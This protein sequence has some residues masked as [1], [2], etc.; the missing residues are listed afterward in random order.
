M[1]LYRIQLFSV[2]R[3][4]DHQH[5]PV[6]LQPTVQTL[7]AYLL[8]NRHR[9][10]SREVLSGL[11]WGEM[12]ESKARR[13]LSTALWRLRKVLEPEDASRGDLVVTTNS[14]E[15]GL[16]CQREKVWLDVAAFEEKARCGLGCPSSEL[17]AA[18]IGQL[19]E[20]VDLYVGDLLEGFYA[21]WV[22]VHREWLRGQYIRCLGRLMRFHG[23]EGAYEKGIYYGRKILAIDPLR[24][25]IHRAMMRL[26]HQNGKWPQVLQQYESCRQ[27]LAEEL[28]I[29]PM[30]ETQALFRQLTASRSTR[31]VAHPQHDRFDHPG[32][33]QQALRE[34]DQAL[35][36]LEEVREQVRHA[37]Q[38]VSQYLKHR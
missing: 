20:A 26:Y 38:A 34:L 13:C 12:D 5:R 19:E 11:F 8:L 1:T 10:H 14:G 18:E 28:Q 21:D 22:L 7:L 15:I 6:S 9:F 33:L 27:I 37:R 3:L 16:N 23:R 35:F 29:E 4:D 36:S 32:N 24:E 17:G 30:P 2:I 31:T 25:E